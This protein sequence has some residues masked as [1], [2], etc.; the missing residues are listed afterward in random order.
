MLL[1]HWSSGIVIVTVI[2]IELSMLWPNSRSCCR[3]RTID[4]TDEPV[5]LMRCLV[6]FCTWTNDQP[7]DLEAVF[8]F[9]QLSAVAVCLAVGLA[10]SHYNAGQ[11]LR[12]HCWSMLDALST[13]CKVG[14]VTSNNCDLASDHC[15]RALT[16]GTGWLCKL[17]IERSESNLMTTSAIADGLRVL[18][19][20]M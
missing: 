20:P 2:W 5:G 8:A 10:G 11:I 9:L 16:L 4:G 6:I 19:Q 1:S 12:P 3:Q 18:C 14:H 17:F 15:V 13:S 7:P